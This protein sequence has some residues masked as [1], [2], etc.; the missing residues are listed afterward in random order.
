MQGISASSLPKLKFLNTTIV[1]SQRIEC[2]GMPEHF[3][4][5]TVANNSYGRGK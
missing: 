5:I 4:T 3:F 2:M 1:Y